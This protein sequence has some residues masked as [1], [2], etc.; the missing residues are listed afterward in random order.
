MKKYL[1]T[2]IAGFG[3]AVL[4]IVPGIKSFSCCLIVPAAAILA[5]ILDQ[6]VNKNFERI[7]ASKAVVFGLMTGLFATFFI[8]A[9]DILITFITKSND[10]IEALPQSESL[11][12]ELNFGP[13]AEESLK[14]L[15]QMAKQI[16]KSGFSPLYLFILFISNFI[17]NTIFGMIGG[18]IGMGLLNKRRTEE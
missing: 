17:T 13:M 12:R 18:L 11:I 1:P 2:F 10:F 3:A 6:R 9:L 8:T 5:L 16:Q 4:S 7:A 14:L 15:K